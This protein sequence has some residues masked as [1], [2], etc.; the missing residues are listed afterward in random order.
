MI[1]G[2][3]DITDIDHGAAYQRH[4][5]LNRLRRFMDITEWEHT[6]TST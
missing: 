5:A 1:N 4:Y 6:D 2:Q 3:N